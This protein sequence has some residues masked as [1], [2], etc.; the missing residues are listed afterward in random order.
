MATEAFGLLSKEEA[1]ELRTRLRLM[2]PEAFEREMLEE[3][4]LPLRTVGTALGIEPDLFPGEDDMYHEVFRY[5][6]VEITKTR[7]KLPHINTIDDA[8]R[9]LSKATKVLVITGAGISTSLG[10]PD[11]RSKETGFYEKLRGMGI[12]D[13]EEVFDI[14]LFDEDPR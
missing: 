14:D 3:K 8:A 11:F 1:K 2:G 10:I 5:V 7:A 12:E 9:L 13:P 6:M 4:G